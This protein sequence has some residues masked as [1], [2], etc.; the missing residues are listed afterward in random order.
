MFKGTYAPWYWFAVVTLMVLVA[1]LLTN[2]TLLQ[3]QRF[4]ESV[5][6]GIPVGV[7]KWV[8][9]I[10][11]GG[12]CGQVITV[13]WSF[14]IAWWAP[15]VPLVVSGIAN[16]VFPSAAAMVA[17]TRGVIA[18]S[19][20]VHENSP[21]ND[22]ET[23]AMD[24]SLSTTLVEDLESGPL[25]DATHSASNLDTTM[26]RTGYIV[27]IMFAIREA[28]KDSMDANQLGIMLTRIKKSLVQRG[29]VDD[30]LFPRLWKV[31]P[32][33]IGVKGHFSGINGGPLSNIVLASHLI[34]D[35]WMPADYSISL[36]L[37]IYMTKRIAEFQL[38]ART[39]AR[40]PAKVD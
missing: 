17:K 18:H 7:P 6:S 16:T 31:Y 39:L 20:K 26:F 5:A 28:L 3:E 4:E 19:L 14:T 21:T 15:V 37:D 25:F 24:Q 36:S 40:L 9:L 30:T 29:F 33:C 27:V 22:K 34:G 10:A 1:R 23:G 38:Q 32:E 13:L 8:S 12:F 2:R 11:F 35:G